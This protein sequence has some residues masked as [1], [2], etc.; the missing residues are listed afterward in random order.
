MPDPLDVK[1]E[2]LG[3]EALPG[4]PCIEIPRFDGQ[5]GGDPELAISGFHQLRLKASSHL[6][7]L[8]MIVKDENHGISSTLESIAP[9]IDRWV[10]L[11]TGST[12]GTQDT[13]R[14]VLA[15]I[16]GEL[17]EEPFTDFSTARNRALDLARVGY[18]TR[19][20]LMLD[21]DDHVVGGDLLRALL[22]GT[23]A[24][25]APGYLVNVRRNELDYWLPL[26]TRSRA[27]CRYTGLVHEYLDAAITAKIAGVQVIQTRPAQSAEATQKRWKR[28]LEI[29][30]KAYAEDPKNPRTLFYLAQTYGC[31]GDH[32]SALYAYDERIAVGGTHKPEI[33][34]AMLRR[35]QSMSEIGMPWEVVQQ[36]Y[37]EAHQYAPSRAEP[38]HQIALHYRKTDQ[39]ALAF[40]F[41]SRAADIH[42]PQDA[43]FVDHDVYAYKANEDAAISGFYLQDAAARA[44]GAEYARQAVRAR[45]HNEQT[46][47]NWAFY[48]PTVAE[49][50]GA[51]TKRV[52]FEVEPPYHCTNPSIFYDAGVWRC[53]VRTTN[54]EIVNGQY[55]TPDD[56]VIYTRNYLLELDGDLKVTS[57]KEMIDRTGI[58]RSAYPV[59]GFE[60]CRLFRWRDSLYCTA[61]VCDFDLEREDRGPREIVLMKIADDGAI[62]S[63]DVLRGRWSHLAQKNWMPIE[64]PMSNDLHLVYDAATACGVTVKRSEAGIEAC[65]DERTAP[66]DAVAGRL[67]GSSQAIWLAAIGFWLAIVHDVAHLPKGRRIYTHRFVLFSANTAMAPVGLS[68]PFCFEKHGIE[69]CAGLGLEGN[70]LVASYGVDDSSANLATFDLMKVL[71]LCRT[72][73]FVI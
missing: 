46:R 69:F 27:K 72:A 23:L 17:Y 48:A 20:A 11:D 71:A 36:A 34:Q 59:H 39:H 70:R 60:D 37:L 30:R 52:P 21:A 50:Y 1:C 49:K 24:D 45:P 57:S 64:V 66:R 16:P 68:D 67:R 56:N 18:D 25:S 73:P 29:L 12:D 7:C 6:L 10:I 55:L 15:G 42:M 58:P 35:A 38:L 43:L 51:T 13:I 62:E 44:G 8:V 47:A 14:R 41:A 31:L 54:Y 53:V 9:F 4:S 40:L 2:R 3:C 28:D 19:Y 5:P 33:A 65:W 63:A 61:T 32:R 22:R 26:V